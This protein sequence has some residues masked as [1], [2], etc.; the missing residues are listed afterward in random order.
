V[1][2]AERANGPIPRGVDPSY[3]WGEAL[4]ELERIKPDAK[5]IN[6]ETSVTRS[7]DCWKGKGINYR[8][9]PE[10]LFGFVW[11]W[12]RGVGLREF[13]SL[14]AEPPDGLLRNLQAQAWLL[15]RQHAAVLDL[16]G[17]RKRAR[18]PGHVLDRT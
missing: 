14:D 17:F 2:L 4:G 16:G 1:D 3:I 18:D 15:R 10:T 12:V 9:H 13:V 7:D 8:M 11:A 5:I 6:L